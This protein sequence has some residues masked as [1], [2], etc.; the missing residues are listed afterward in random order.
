MENLKFNVEVKDGYMGCNAFVGSNYK[1]Y[2]RFTE[3]NKIVKSEF[4]KAY[5]NVKISCRGSSFAGGQ[6]C[7]A[8]LILNKEQAIKSFE[9]VKKAIEEYYNKNKFCF[10]VCRYI[11]YYDNDNDLLNQSYDTQ[12]KYVYDNYIKSCEGGRHS[13]NIDEIDEI[14]LTTEAYNMIKLLNNMYDSFN[15][16]ENNGMVDYFD[17]MFYKNI[18]IK[19]TE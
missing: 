7:T 19:I 13:N 1:G 4:K 17:N 18:F 2:M 12:L 5:K 6:D 16:T 15:Y 10:Q 14:I 11:Y 3:I 9:E 8:T